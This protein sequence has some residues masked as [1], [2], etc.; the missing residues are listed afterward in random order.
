MQKSHLPDEGM[1]IIMNGY[2]LLSTYYMIDIMVTLSDTLFHLAL[3]TL[4]GNCN[5]TIVPIIQRRKLKL[6]KR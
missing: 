6:L 5:D 1:I 2:H 3:I 4:L